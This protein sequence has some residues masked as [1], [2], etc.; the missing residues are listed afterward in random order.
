MVSPKLAAASA[1]RSAAPAPPASAA[2]ALGRAGLPV[3]LVD[4]DVREIL[5]REGVLPLR[6]LLVSLTGRGDRQLEDRERLGEIALA[7]EGLRRRPAEP[8]FAREDRLREQE[9]PRALR[10]PPRQPR[11]PEHPA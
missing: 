2:A 1:A 6:Q 10:H 8:A 4:R 7:S 11:G 5:A 3:L 9:H